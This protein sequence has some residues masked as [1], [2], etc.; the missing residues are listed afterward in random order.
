VEG[1]SRDLFG[2]WASL[3]ESLEAGLVA[4]PS[5]CLLWTGTV[6]RS[7]YGVCRGARAHRLAYALA[8]GVWETS[9]TI[10]HLCGIRT[11]CHP[12]H[13]EAVTAEENTRRVWEV[14]GKPTNRDHHRPRGS[15]TVLRRP[16]STVEDKVTRLASRRGAEGI[17]RADAS[18]AL[19]GDTQR[20]LL[21]QALEALVADGTLRQVGR[22]YWLAEKAA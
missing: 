16:S 7:G 17:T 6:D 13:L 10:D 9:L 11:C 2:A 21:E 8:T 18:R 19:T 22:R 4:D 1:V 15:G 20:A 3:R 12:D 14:E 5:G